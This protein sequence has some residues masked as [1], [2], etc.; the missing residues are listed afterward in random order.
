MTVQ[1]EIATLQNVGENVQNAIF[2]GLNIT[3]I[4]W[5][6]TARSKNS[7]LGPN[8]SDLTLSV[9]NTRMPMIRKPNFSDVTG[10]LP[11]E[12]FQVTVGNETD[13]GELKRIPLKDY[14]TD[15]STYTTAKGGSN[16]VERRDEQILCSAQACILPLEES[17]EVTFVPQ[18]FNYQSQKNDPAVLVIV[19]TSQGTS[20][21]VITEYA[22]KL[23]FNRGGQ[24]TQYLA[25]RLSQD[26]KERNV[27][28]EGEM[29]SEEQDRNVLVIYQI[30]LKQKP[31]PVTRNFFG[32]LN[33][34]Y[35]SFPVSGGALLGGLST[36]NQTLCLSDGEDVSEE[37]CSFGF[38]MT[39]Q[40]TF[41]RS[42]SA[43]GR[44]KKGMEHAM[45]RAAEI[46]EGPF[47]SLSGFDLV[48]DDRYP[49][50][51]T[52]QFYRVTDDPNID[53][54]VFADISRKIET[55]YDLAKEK[56]SLVIDQSQR[57]TEATKSAGKF[58]GKMKEA[59]TSSTP[60]FSGFGPKEP[61][62]ADFIVV[63]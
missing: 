55:V 5:E 32:A 21:Q 63:D 58:L 7:S 10:D 1:N 30:P 54:E 46:S 25:K 40:C 14:L 34:N 36:K 19:A 27:A 45:L 18:L 6:D 8:I 13:N 52:F 37:S 57:I 50:R 47:K 28:L 4:A 33:S 11:I 62:P 43:R 44:V 15:L 48:R 59:P 23:Y 35:G 41:S 22:Q 12:H 16:I 9:G 3:T 26:R 29:T 17:G 38:G 56:G 39:R 20:A 60:L 49:I 61:E 24:A 31:K 42:G 2:H 53:S 51:A